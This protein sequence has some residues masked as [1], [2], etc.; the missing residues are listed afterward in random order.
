M[1]SEK[2]VFVGNIPYDAREEDL[3]ACFEAIGPVVSFRLVR[4]RDSRKPKGYGFCEFKEKEYARC[5][6]KHM[7][8]YEF[9]GR[10]LRVDYSEKHRNVLPA[11]EPRGQSC[12]V[13][14]FMHLGPEEANYLFSVLQKYS[15]SNEQEFYTILKARP[16]LILALM[17]LMDKF[18]GEMGNLRTGQM[19]DGLLPIPDSMALQGMPGFPQPP[20]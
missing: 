18:N 15:H 5:A 2:S 1:T 11:N 10:P 8:N 7:N 17:K 12:L 16:Y 4:D 20:Y 3:K 9:N 13:E 19:S 14:E 6:I